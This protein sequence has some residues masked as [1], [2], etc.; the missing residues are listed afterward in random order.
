[1]DAVISVC[2]FCEG[3]GPRILFTT[4]VFREGDLDVSSLAG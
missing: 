1:M 2:I 4:Q 3:H